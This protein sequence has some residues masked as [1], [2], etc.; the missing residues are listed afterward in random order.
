MFSRLMYFFIAVYIYV[1]DVKWSVP[2]CV[3]ENKPLD[4]LS[5][6]IVRFS[7]CDL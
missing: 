3:K 6:Q 2:H 7:Q 4:V 5:F 1:F